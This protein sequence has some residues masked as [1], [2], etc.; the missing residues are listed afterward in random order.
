MRKLFILI[1]LVAVTAI[2]WFREDNVELY[3]GIALA[4]VLSVAYLIGPV[5][6]VTMKAIRMILNEEGFIC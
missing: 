4:V 1:A 5:F 3:F 2:I 6:W